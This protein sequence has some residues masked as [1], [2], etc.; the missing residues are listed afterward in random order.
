L[1]GLDE[2]F[3]LVSVTLTARQ[4]IVA[5]GGWV[6]ANG[7]VIVNWLPKAVE[8]ELLYQVVKALVS[9]MVKSVAVSGPLVVGVN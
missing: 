4:G 2:P 6:N 5:P 9:G 7:T 1:E 8:A 3:E